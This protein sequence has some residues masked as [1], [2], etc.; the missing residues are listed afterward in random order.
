M[1]AHLCRIKGKRMFMKKSMDRRSFLKG[2]AVVGAAALGSAALAG[3]GSSSTSSASASAAASSAASSE[4]S[5]SASA[6]A[7]ASSTELVVSYSGVQCELP[8][9]VAHEM[10]YFEQ[11]NVNSRLRR[12]GEGEQLAVLLANGEYNCQEM[13]P[14][15]MLSIAEGSG[16]VCVDN[17]HSGC[18]SCVAGA[19]SGITDVAGLVGKKVGRS[20]PKN[21]AYLLTRYELVKLGYDPNEIETLVEWVN[22]DNDLLTTSLANGEVDAI[23][24]GE[25][26]ATMAVHEGG[27]EIWNNWAGDYADKSCCFVGIA[28]STLDEDPDLARRACKALREA[29]DYIDANLEECVEMAHDKEYIKTD[30]EL[31]YEVLA[32]Y[33]FFG[34]KSG[35]DQ[36]DRSAE[37]YW[38]ALYTAGLLED[39][40]ENPTDD[41]LKAYFAEKGKDSLQYVGENLDA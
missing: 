34:N 8:F 16:M 40:P 35:K 7:A 29:E 22:I 6:S 15:Q 21:P 5:A 37:A 13:G 20:G 10:G 11:N 23:C 18:L 19:D 27:T 38:M 26:R 32:H 1:L 36:F 17:C 28:Q 3:C 4:A 30:I 41:E 12:V 14:A 2:S 9:F 33:A 39:A 24:L 31:D 25:P